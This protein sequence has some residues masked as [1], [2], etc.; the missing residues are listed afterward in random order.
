MNGP[1]SQVI[2]QTLREMTGF[3]TRPVCMLFDEFSDNAAVRADDGLGIYEATRHLLA[4]G[5]RHIC[6]FVFPEHL[7]PMPHRRIIG[8]ARALGE[9]GLDAAEYLHLYDTPLEWL[10]PVVVPHSLRERIA[11]SEQM[12]SIRADFQ[13]YLRAEKHITACIGLNDA[14]ALNI[15]Y[16]CTDAGWAVPEDM[17]IIGFDDTDS[18]MG[19]T[20]EQLLTTVH[21][22]LFEI[23]QQ[24]VAQLIQLISDPQQSP[25]HV[26][27]P[28]RLIVRAS[29]STA[30]SGG[31]FLS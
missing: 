16:A 6:L 19:P 30:P 23:G 5:H 9:Q 11:L 22:P 7:D 21:V 31:S 18:M 25:E 10:N 13:Q 28:T 27:L 17:S 29:T 1:G 12:L 2:I 8:V 4:L 14:T 3:G 20:G 26:V 15:W 24:A